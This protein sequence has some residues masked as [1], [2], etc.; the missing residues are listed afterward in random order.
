MDT[1]KML[2]VGKLFPKMKQHSKYYIKIEHRTYLFL[3]QQNFTYVD[4]NK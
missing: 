2:K 1:I 4:K 3:Y